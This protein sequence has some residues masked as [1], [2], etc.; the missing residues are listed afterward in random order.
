MPALQPRMVASIRRL[1]PPVI[2][3]TDTDTAILMMAILAMVIRQP[4]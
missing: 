1:R 4:I 3:D 2:T